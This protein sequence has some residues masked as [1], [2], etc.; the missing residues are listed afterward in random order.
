M[1]TSEKASREEKTIRSVLDRTELYWERYT[2][3][4]PIVADLLIVHG[5]F[6]HGSIFRDLSEYL[7]NFGI[8]TTMFDL[9]GHGKSGGTRGYI[10]A[11][12][13]YVQD[14]EAALATLDGSRPCF[15]HWK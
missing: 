15:C 2:P 5:Y 4:V 8:S 11:W 10:Q 1:T 12:E 7:A 6:Q 13:D 3:S 14:F 9:R